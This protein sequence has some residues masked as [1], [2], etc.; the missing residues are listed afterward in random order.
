MPRRLTAILLVL[1]SLSVAVGLVDPVDPFVPNR[2]FVAD[3]GDELA[4]FNEQGEPQ[5]TYLTGFSE[6]SGLVSAHDVAFGPDGALYA[7][8]FFLDRVLVYDSAGGAPVAT[9]SA[10]DLDGPTDLLFGPNGDLFVASANDD[11]V[12]RFDAA[13]IDPVL[14]ISAPGLDDPRGLAIGPHGHLFVSSY[15]NDQIF[16]FDA[17]G[18]LLAMHGGGSS[19]DGPYG[20]AFSP[21]NGL[22]YV[23]SRNS[24]QVL[25]F[26]SSGA[27][28]AALSDEELRAPT[29][30]TFGPDGNLF[31]ASHGTGKVLVMDSAG[32]VVD[33]VIGQ[34]QLS[35]PTGLAFSPFVI[36]TKVTGRSFPV[37]GP[38]N[39]VKQPARLNWAPGSGQASLM[40]LDPKGSNVDVDPFFGER[41]LVARGF[42]RGP[43][44]PGPSVRFVGKE[45]DVGSALDGIGSLAFVSKGN[46]LNITGLNS[47]TGI[48]NAKKVSGHVLKLGPQGE[49]NAD[50]QSK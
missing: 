1:S 25:A 10:A 24:D 11:A 20:L 47:L 8:D 23:A 4:E 38:A 17:G 44:F 6:L 5:P 26:N 22:L 41:A 16:E 43:V 46:S 3:G 7:S 35:A 32:G 12:L 31:V 42:E 19:L 33:R 48:F 45:L 39:Q 28:I 29:S 21:R 40:L 30:L 49:T 13:G 27:P 2:L 37:D 15:G 9:I 34:D 50:F 36:T 18:G 14:V